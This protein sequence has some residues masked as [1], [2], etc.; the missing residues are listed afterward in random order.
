MK[1]YPEPAW[2]RIFLSGE[3]RT[4][5]LGE[6]R[7]AH[8]LS[9]RKAEFYLLPDSSGHCETAAERFRL[10]PR[11]AEFQSKTSRT[12]IQAQ[13]QFPARDAI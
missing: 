12:I 2:P 7:S 13:T 3:V 10:Q 9:I 6:N 11:H 1:K 8:C 5:I 4:S